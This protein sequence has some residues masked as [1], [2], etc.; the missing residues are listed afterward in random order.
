MEIAD[1]ITQAATDVM[2]K[3]QLPTPLMGPPITR[4]DLTPV[5]SEMAAWVKELTARLE[6]ERTL[7]LEAQMPQQILKTTLEIYQ[8]VSAG[9]AFKGK[10]AEHQFAKQRMNDIIDVGLRAW[11]EMLGGKPQQE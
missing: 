2:S 10:E 8:A 1:R 4:N 6:T 9:M 7:R 5:V 11:E 3:S